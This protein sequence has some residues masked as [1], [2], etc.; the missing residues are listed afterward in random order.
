MSAKRKECSRTISCSSSSDSDDCDDPELYPMEGFP[1][2]AC[3]NNDYYMKFLMGSFQRSIDPSNY[4]AKLKFWRDMILTYCYY[5]RSAS[6]NIDELQNA[7]KRRNGIPY[8]LNTIVQEMLQDKQILRRS[9]YEYDPANSW[10]GW[11]MSFV[12]KPL[13]WGLRQ[14]RG[15]EEKPEKIEYIHLK[16]LENFTDELYKV[17]QQEPG[18]IYH[19]AKLVQQIHGKFY[20]TEDCIKLCLQTLHSQGLIGLDY[21][22][23]NDNK[24][25]IHLVKI[26]SEADPSIEISEVNRAV[27]NLKMAQN[28]LLS[29]LEDIEKEVKLNE[30]KA[31]QYIKDGKRQLAK[32][33]LRKKQ[34][35]EKNHEKRSITLHNIEVLMCNVEEAETNGV[36]LDAYK[37]GSKALQGMLNAAGLNYDN[38]EE[39]ISDVRDTIDIHNEVQETLSKPN[40]DNE[41]NANYDDDA[42]ESELRQILNETEGNKKSMTSTP[43]QTI[44]PRISAS[45]PVSGAAAKIPTAQD[46]ANNVLQNVKISDEELAAMLADLDVEETSPA[47]SLPKT[48]ENDEALATVL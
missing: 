43:K 1:Y 42:I 20:L 30:D 28:S 3:W 6:F 41:I 25:Q 22:I 47:K 45:T 8:G 36:I 44:A 14:I 23:A 21:T 46:D 38:V 35:L 27:H 29:Q 37:I 12:K 11:A 19:L 32:A 48:T 9:E 15:A 10:T 24:R 7:F 34:L 17:L 31:R 18:Q 40:I 5:K 33:Y 13:T 26:P 2:P 39:V 4:D 16:I